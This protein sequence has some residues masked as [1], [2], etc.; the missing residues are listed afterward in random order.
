VNCG[1]LE[2]LHRCLRATP[3]ALAKGPASRIM[4]GEARAVYRTLCL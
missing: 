4:S 2:S 1:Q 3:Y